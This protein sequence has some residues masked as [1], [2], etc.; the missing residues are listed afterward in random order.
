MPAHI[1]LIVSGEEYTLWSTAL[2]SFLHSPV[3]LFLLGL[4]ILLSTL[5]L[6]T[7]KLCPLSVIGQVPHPYKQQVKL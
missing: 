5:F 4:N 1:I 3:T 6:N 7:L 2:C